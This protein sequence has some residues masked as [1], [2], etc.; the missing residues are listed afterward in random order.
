MPRPLAVLT[1]LDTAR[2]EHIPRKYAKIILSTKID[3][4]NKLKYSIIDSVFQLFF[5]EVLVD[6]PVY[7]DDASEKDEG[8]RRKDYET[9]VHISQS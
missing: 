5:L 8:E 3:L 4:M 9:V 2:Y 6:A 7:P 1:F